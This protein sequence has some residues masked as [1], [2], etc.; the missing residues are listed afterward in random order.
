MSVVFATNRLYCLIFQQKNCIRVE[1][2][3]EWVHE[4]FWIFIECC[5]S[6]DINVERGCCVKTQNSD[7]FD[8][9][10]YKHSPLL[11]LLSVYMKK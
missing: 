2:T 3:K 8:L 11:S 1:I 7:F 10:P 5:R 6:E 4:F 9:L